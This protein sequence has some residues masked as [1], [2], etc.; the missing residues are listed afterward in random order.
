VINARKI[1]EIVIEK[2]NGEKILF[3]AKPVAHGIVQHLELKMDCNGNIAVYKHYKLVK[4]FMMEE[5]RN[6]SM[7]DRNDATVLIEVKV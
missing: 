3:E 2:V 5:V 7:S 1:G 6:I 4:Q